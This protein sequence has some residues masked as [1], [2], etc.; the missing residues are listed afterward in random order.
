MEL[1]GE[2]FFLAFPGELSVLIS[3]L[4]SENFGFSEIGSGRCP[5]APSF[6]FLQHETC[7]ALREHLTIPRFAFGSLS[8]GSLIVKV[9]RCC[10]F[11]ATAYSFRDRAWFSV[12]RGSEVES[13]PSVIVPS[14]IELG[15]PFCL[16]RYRCHHTIGPD[17][18]QCL[19]WICNSHTT[20]R[21]LDGRRRESSVSC[22]SLF[23]SVA[24]LE[25]S[26]S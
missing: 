19:S 5:R 12:C 21:P 24:P 23:S 8:A 1:H 22:L 17:A 18:C 4:C 6:Y 13:S 3:F 2:T 10:K 14:E 20:S 7:T 16:L 15:S 26:H 9:S 25:C 11:S